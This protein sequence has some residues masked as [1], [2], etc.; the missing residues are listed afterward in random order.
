MQWSRINLF[1]NNFLSRAGPQFPHQVIGGPNFPI[2]SFIYHCITKCAPP[3]VPLRQQGPNFTFFP[4]QV[5]YPTPQFPRCFIKGF[6]FPHCVIK[7]PQIS[8]APSRASNFLIMS[9]KWWPLISH[10]VIKRFQFSL[11]HQGALIVT[12]N[13]PLRYQGVLIYHCVSKGYPFPPPPIA[14]SKEP[15]FPKYTMYMRYVLIKSA[16]FLFLFLVGNS[17]CYVGAPP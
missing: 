17:S 4:R 15:K 13:F 5:I 1:E 11:R 7:G 2:V 16:I 9:S 6:Q 10:P 14:S 3:H 12:S 8:I